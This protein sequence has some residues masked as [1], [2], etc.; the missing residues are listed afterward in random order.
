MLPNGSQASLSASSDSV[1]ILGLGRICLTLGSVSGKHV[2]VAPNSESD[3]V[4]PAGPESWT[5]EC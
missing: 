1:I 3:E 4:L 2:Q 5:Q